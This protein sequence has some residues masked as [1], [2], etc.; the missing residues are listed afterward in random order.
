MLREKRSEHLRRMSRIKDKQRSEYFQAIARH[1]FRHR[2]TPFFLSSKDLDLITRWEKIG[3]PLR[4]VVEGITRAFENLGSKQR[5]QGKILSLSYCHPQVVKAFHQFKERKV[6]S[7]GSGS[8]RRDKKEKAMAEIKMFI[9]ILPIEVSFLKNVYS[10][11]YEL[12]SQSK[13][14]EEALELLDQEVERLLMEKFLQEK[15]EEREK[16]V[17]KDRGRNENQLEIRKIKWVKQVRERHKIPYISL[18]YY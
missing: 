4:V 1:F 8:D 9:K 13:A 15:P 16:D 14:E 11:A 17:Q 7:K 12:L 3:I 2:G 5:K 6:G 18:Y 10:Q